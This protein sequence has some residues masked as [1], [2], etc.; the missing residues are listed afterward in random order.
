MGPGWTKQN[1][2]CWKVFRRRRKG[3]Y[4]MKE[5]LSSQY[6]VQYSLQTY[7]HKLSDK[8]I[9]NLNDHDGI[10]DKGRPQEKMHGKARTINRPRRR[11]RK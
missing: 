10:T 7:I 1:G 3:N 2:L 9:L 8:N 5:E 11:C 4:Q 6:V